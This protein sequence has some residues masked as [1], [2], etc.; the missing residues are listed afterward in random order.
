[1]TDNSCA[2]VKQSSVF[3]L[4]VDDIAKMSASEQKTLWIKLNKE[5]LTVLAKEIDTKVRPSDLSDE[6]IASLVKKA[7]RYEKKKKG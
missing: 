3:A 6:E 1:M 7:R 2:I 5:K 4:L